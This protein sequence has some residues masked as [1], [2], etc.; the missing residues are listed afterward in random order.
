[1]TSMNNVEPTLVMPIGITDV[2]DY[3]DIL[4]MPDD[5]TRAPDIEEFQHEVMNWAGLCDIE[6]QTACCCD[7]PPKKVE[8]DDDGNALPEFVPCDR[9][10]KEEELDQLFDIEPGIYSKPKKL[11]EYREDSIAQM[12]DDIVRDRRFRDKFIAGHDVQVA[13]RYITEIDISR[14][15]LIKKYVS[16]DEIKMII[17]LVDKLIGQ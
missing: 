15:D 16:D 7:K 8:Y 1:M 9:I 3:V 17:E 5:I 6:E 12:I 2:T 14:E 13:Q 11:D 10:I 4:G